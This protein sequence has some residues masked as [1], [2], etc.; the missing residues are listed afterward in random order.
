MCSS[1]LIKF[2]TILTTVIIAIIITPLP[3]AFGIRRKFGG[4]PAV[5]A[6]IRF[7]CPTIIRSISAILPNIATH[8]TTVIIAMF[9][10]QPPIF[11]ICGSLIIPKRADTCL[12]SSVK[13]GSRKPAVVDCEWIKGLFEITKIRGRIVLRRCVR[14]IIVHKN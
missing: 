7:V 4:G 10:S 11:A 2:G 13:I 1:Y 12:I 14:S 3:L 5:F 6:S 9:G 8:W